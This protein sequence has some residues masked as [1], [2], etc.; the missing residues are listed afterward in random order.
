MIGLLLSSL[1]WSACAVILS[2]GAGLLVVNGK[3]NE[4]IKSWAKSFL[5]WMRVAKCMTTTKRRVA[6]A[7]FHDVKQQVLLGVMRIVLIDEIP[8]SLFIHVS[9]GIRLGCTMYQCLTGL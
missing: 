1:E 3:H 8:H 4:L 9:V 6:G 2:H 5:Q 7:D